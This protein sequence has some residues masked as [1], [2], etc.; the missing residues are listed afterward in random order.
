M[1]VCQG[2]ASVSRLALMPQAPRRP[3]LAHPNPCAAYWPWG[4]RQRQ[5]QKLGR[6]CSGMRRDCSK[7]L[8][9]S[10]SPAPVSPTRALAFA[11]SRRRE[12][13]LMHDGGGTPRKVMS[14]SVHAVHWAWRPMMAVNRCQPFVQCTT[15]QNNCKKVTGEVHGP[16]PSPNAPSWRRPGI[17]GK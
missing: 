15:T 3:A 4:R 2:I 17:K 13:M 16:V 6:V 5:R 8:K 1:R 14:L 10:A 11:M 12:R 9:S 7:V